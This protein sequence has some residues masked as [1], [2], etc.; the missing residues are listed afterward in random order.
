[1]NKD[2]IVELY[3]IMLGYDS[4][5]ITKTF[6]LYSRGEIIK[7]HRESITPLEEY[8]IERTYEEYLDNDDMKFINENL[9]EIFDESKFRLADEDLFEEISELLDEL[10]NYDFNYKLKKSFDM[11][12]KE[13]F[14]EDKIEEIVYSDDLDKLLDYFKDLKDSDELFGL[15]EKSVFNSECYNN[16]VNKIIPS[17]EY[18]EENL[19]NE[20]EF[21]M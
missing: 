7:G 21:E 9:V 18:I 15:I 8:A 13:S 16:M 17:L 3:N 12:T 4:T 19:D 20:K 14:D 2:K 11:D 10:D 5:T 6:L 1:M